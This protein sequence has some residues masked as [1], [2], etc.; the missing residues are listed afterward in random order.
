MYSRHQLPVSRAHTHTQI[1]VFAAVVSFSFQP[2]FAPPGK[3]SL[4]MSETCAAGEP[5]APIE[6][7]TKPTRRTSLIPK[8]N[9]DDVT[10]EDISRA[11]VRGVI[12]SV[13]S[14]VYISG[15][16]ALL[17]KPLWAF[18]L[19]EETEGRKS[20]SFLLVP[21]FLSLRYPLIHRRT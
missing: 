8:A 16:M 2:L 7:V 19:V 5:V 3:T 18:F 4:L 14:T 20:I 15:L 21:L 17:G 12:T 9:A 11:K 13:Y 1:T 6:E 10:F